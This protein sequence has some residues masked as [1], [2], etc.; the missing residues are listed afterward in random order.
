[1][2]RPFTWIRSW[3]WLLR[4]TAFLQSACCQESL[5]LHQEDK[6]FSP[7]P[8]CS[9]GLKSWSPLLNTPSRHLTDDSSRFEWKHTHTPPLSSSTHTETPFLDIIYLFIQ[10]LYDPSGLLKL[11]LHSWRGPWSQVPG[12]KPTLFLSKNNK[13]KPWYGALAG[14]RQQ[15]STLQQPRSCCDRHVW[16]P[17]ARGPH[18]IC[19]CWKTDIVS[20]AMTNG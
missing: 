7:R 14:A 6:N 17:E 12:S 15:G 18:A 4:L 11:L 9:P 16:I 3:P 2:S 13:Q 8:P 5:F 20:V 10:R 19:I 1:M